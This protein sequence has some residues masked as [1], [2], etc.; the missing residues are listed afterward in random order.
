M[1]LYE[2]V[3]TKSTYFVQINLFFMVKRTLDIAVSLLLLILLSPLMVAIGYRLYKKE[4]KPILFR[5]L[6]VGKNGRTFIKYSFRTMMNTSK[7]IRSL[8]PHPFPSSWEKGVPNYFK[9]SRDKN[10]V[11]TL[12]GTWLRNYHFD[13]I[14]QLINVLKGDMSFVGPSPEI[15][16]IA[17]YYNRY[18]SSRL[19][20]RPGITGYAQMKGASNNNHGQKIKYDLYYIHNYSYKLDAKILYRFIKDIF[21]KK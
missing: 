19:K 21:T 20:V 9:F 15:P 7:V 1:G 5:E 6:C 16:E 13:K 10:K 4:G 12:T 14:P 17:D 3:R 8:P 11:Y 2:S 18:Q